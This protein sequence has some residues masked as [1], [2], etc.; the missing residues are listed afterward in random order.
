[1][2]LAFC[3]VLIL[4]FVLFLIIYDYI[5]FL[6]LIMITSVIPTVSSNDVMAVLLR[7]PFS[8]NVQSLSHLGMEY[9]I[10][11]LRLCTLPQII[12]ESPWP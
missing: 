5:L 6:S 8:K 7:D 2:D 3:F 9:G 12:L 1:M 4:P 10:Y 11:C